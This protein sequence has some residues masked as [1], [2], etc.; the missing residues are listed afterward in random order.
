MTNAIIRRLLEFCSP[1]FRVFKEVPARGGEIKQKIEALNALAKSHP[2]ILLTDLDA[3][4]CAPM[5]RM[6]CLPDWCSLRT[7]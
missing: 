6:I 7:F 4:A 5:L 1:R 3:T 2:V